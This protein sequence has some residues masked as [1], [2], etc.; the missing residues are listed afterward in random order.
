MEIELRT[1]HRRMLRKVFGA[2]RRLRDREPLT[3]ESSDDHTVDSSDSG[4]VVQ[5]EIQPWSDS[6]KRVTCTVEAANAHLGIEDWI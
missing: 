2:G 4:G 1:A 5:P 6:L 3:D